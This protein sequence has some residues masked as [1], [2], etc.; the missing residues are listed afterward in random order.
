[1]CLH[2]CHT[3][4][5]HR[6]RNMKVSCLRDSFPPLTFSLPCLSLLLGICDSPPRLSFAELPGVVNNSYP[7]GT[8]LKYSCHPGYVLDSGKSPVVTC[9][10]NSTCFPNDLG[11]YHVTSFNFINVGA[12][13][14]W[15]TT[16]WCG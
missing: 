10:A 13:E 6:M 12:T 15:T 8:E 4:S 14:H 11:S 2:A 1:T 16:A 3:V 7:V 9:L 5:M